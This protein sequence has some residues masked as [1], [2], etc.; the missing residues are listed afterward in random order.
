MSTNKCCLCSKECTSITRFKNWKENEKECLKQHY[1]H[2]LLPETK[3]CRRH[4]LEAAHNHSKPQYIPK[5]KE[6][7]E[8]IDTPIITCIVS[9]CTY[10]QENLK[11]AS[12]KT[13]V[14]VQLLNITQ[15]VPQLLATMQYTLQPYLSSS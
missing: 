10:C 6:N 11:Q 7:T 4:Q 9:E 3:I 12:H 2:E 13:I 15:P 5:W 14:H 8:V 1:D